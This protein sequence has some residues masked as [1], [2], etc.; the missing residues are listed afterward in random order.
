M[1]TKVRSPIR[2]DTAVSSQEHQPA[3]SDTT[4]RN[5]DI[6]I[7]KDQA[8]SEEERKGLSITWETLVP[9]CKWDLPSQIEKKRK[10]K[11]FRVF[12]SSTVNR[13]RHPLAGICAKN[14]HVDLLKIYTQSALLLGNLAF[15]QLC[16]AGDEKVCFN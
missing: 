7:T 11:S 16:L 8:N 10:K 4:A 9:C 13:W 3:P 15:S 12:T 5:T 1:G 6:N 2:K 14:L